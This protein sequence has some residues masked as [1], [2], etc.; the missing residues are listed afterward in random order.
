MNHLYKGKTKNILAWLTAP[1]F[2]FLTSYGSAFDTNHFIFHISLTADTIPVKRLDSIVLKN[3][4]DSLLGSGDSVNN[5]IP[6]MSQPGIIEIKDTTKF[7]NNE[8][9][10]ADTLS[11]KSSK[12]T[13][14][15][16]VAY[17]ADDS[18]V[19]DVPSKKLLLYGKTSSVKYQ[20]SELGA[21]LIE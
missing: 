5:A 12:D 16:P 17:H 1:V 8:T 18:M 4:R 9:V 11:F 19:F 20:T 3:L 6:E 14:D 10:Y 21:P 13:L 7:T 15:A 2:V